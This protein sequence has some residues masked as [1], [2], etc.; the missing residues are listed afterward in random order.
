VLL[1]VPLGNPSHFGLIGTQTCGLL[2][3][4]DFQSQLQRKELVYFNSVITNRKETR[5]GNKVLPEKYPNES[6]WS[7]E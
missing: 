2:L 5:P 1:P 6:T 7:V 3:T 4:V